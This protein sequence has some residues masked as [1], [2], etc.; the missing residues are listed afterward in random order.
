MLNFIT[1]KLYNSLERRT[2]PEKIEK[3][4]EHYIEEIRHNQKR[5]TKTDAFCAKE[6]DTMIEN[7]KDAKSLYEAA[8]FIGAAR[9]YVRNN[10]HEYFK[11]NQK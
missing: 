6:M 8:F 1:K 10:G 9:N 4:K 11:I 2:T 3:V 7:I 5:I